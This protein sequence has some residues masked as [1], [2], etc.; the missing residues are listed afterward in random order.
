MHFY[1]KNIKD[2]NNSTRHFTRTERSIYQDLIEL[3]YDKEHPLKNDIDWINRHVLANSED[4]RKAVEFV[5]SE[6]FKLVDDVYRHDRCDETL[7][8]Y[9]E[10]LEELAE[11]KKNERERQ[12]RY[13]EKR[14]ELFAEV[15]KIG[16]SIAYNSPNSEIEKILSRVTEQVST[17]DMTANQE[18]LT[19]NQQPLTT[20]QVT[21]KKPKSK[22]LRFSDDD[23]VC[24]NYILE[25]IRKLNPEHEVKNIESWANDVRL[26]IEQDKRTHREICELYDWISKDTFERTVVLSTSKL[27]ERWSDLTF[28]R[29]VPANKAAKPEWA[30]IPFPYDGSTIDAW[31]RTHKHPKAPTGCNSYQEY[32]EKTLKPHIEKRLETEGLK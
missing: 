4:E 23:M 12:Q 10:C 5:L 28:K 8:N 22:K 15:K 16:I 27:R 14:K 26:M 18:P 32:V 7:S 19:T 11:K 3:Y 31:V 25:K 9:F 6:K 2:F 17:S 20:N 30:K 13:R 24:A 1:E 29:K 21:S